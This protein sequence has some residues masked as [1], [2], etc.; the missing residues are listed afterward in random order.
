MKVD[1]Y[2]M[3]SESEANAYLTDLF[4]DPANRSMDMV[5]IHA[6]TRIKDA[7]IRMYFTSK[8]KEML[9]AHGHAIE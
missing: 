4:K 5:N 1:P 6:Q 3:D 8:A 9:K 7:N 2:T